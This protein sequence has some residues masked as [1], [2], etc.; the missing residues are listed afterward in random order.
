MACAVSIRRAE[1]SM[2]ETVDEKGRVVESGKEQ[3]GALHSAIATGETSHPVRT[4]HA[5]NLRGTSVHEVPTAPGMG[6][7]EAMAS[8]AKG[9]KRK[10]FYPHG[11]YHNYYGYRA[12]GSF[13]EDPRLRLLQACWF[14]GRHVLDVGCNEGLVTLAVAAGFGCSRTTGVDIDGTLVKRAQRQGRPS[15]LRT[16]EGVT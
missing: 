1:L 10:K 11:N 12:L 15:G 13:D 4:S 6:T 8:E 7:R 14:R 5:L 3:P 16:C 9:G 2:S